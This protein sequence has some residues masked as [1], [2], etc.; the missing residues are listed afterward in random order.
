MSTKEIDN[1][2]NLLKKEGSNIHVRVYLKKTLDIYYEGFW[3]KLAVKR[4]EKF[5]QMVRSY[6]LQT[7]VS[8]KS[9]EDWK[10]SEDGNDFT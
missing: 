9:N 10:H 8:V 2:K 4:K 1:L 5:K 6:L 7:A 3:H